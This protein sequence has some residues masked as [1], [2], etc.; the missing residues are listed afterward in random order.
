MSGQLVSWRDYEGIDGS[1]GGQTSAEELHHLRKALSAG[2]DRD[3]VTAAPG[4]GFPLRVESLEQTLKNTT[5]R[6][7]HIRFWRLIPKIPAFNT[8]EE[9][10]QVQSYGQSRLGAF[11]AEGALPEET[12]AQYE[13][14]FSY[15]KFMGTT[16]RLTHVMSLVKPAHG[17]VI[18]QETIAGTMR[19]L[20]QIERGLYF[21]RDD[22]DPL[23]WTG[24]Q[25]MIEVGA[26]ASNI[27]DLRGKPLSEDN[28]TDAALTIMD[29]PNFG[30]ATH[31]LLNPKNKADLVKTF[32]PR[33]RFDQF[34]K[35][36]DG[37]VGLD[38]RGITTPAGDVQ[39]VPDTFID[40]GGAASEVTVTGDASKRPATPS[41]TT[42]ATSPVNAASLFAVD[43][44][45]NYIYRVV[46]VNAFGNSVSVSV[47]AAVAV[48]AGDDVRFGVTPGAGPLPSYYEIYR[49]AL[50]GAAGT[51]RL[52]TRVR[53]A[54]GGAETTIIDLNGDL[55][56]TFKAFMIQLNL[57][58]IAFKQ[59]AP[60]LKVPLSTQD[61]SIRWMQLIYGTPVLYTPRHNVLFKNIGRSADYVG[62]P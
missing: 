42:A 46:A 48:A 10:N 45:G 12:D 22:L 16:R 60:M 58:N 31:L 9:Y 3:P 26:A 20:E 28:L 23:Q 17:N 37:M 15:I 19:L 41:I 51:E 1:F 8:V 32:F 24:L 56:G 7:E 55:P 62:A 27:I 25:Q 54:V 13:R 4:V 59:L 11:M 39:L 36:D 44:V 29:R 61:T 35:T 5:F 57:D 2:A 6:M 14:K 38:I 30:I 34:Q 33:A 21:A 49:T 52:I 43:D 40:D 47:G 18:A 53:N 50:N